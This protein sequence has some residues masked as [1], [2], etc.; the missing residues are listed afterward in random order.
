MA[1]QLAPRRRHTLQPQGV[2]PRLRGPWADAVFVYVPSVSTWQAR[3]H[4]FALDPGQTDGVSF[5][6][7][8]GYYCT[9]FP[10]CSMRA[11]G[12]TQSL[13]FNTTGM[14]VL[15]IGFYATSGSGIRNLINRNSAGNSGG[16]NVNYFNSVGAGPRI[17]SSYNHPSTG[18][19]NWDSAW[20]NGV[21]DSTGNGSFTTATNT[22]YVF[23]GTAA[24]GPAA[25]G[26]EF[27]MGK[28]SISGQPGG[29]TG[30]ELVVI[31][32]RKFTEQQMYEITRDPYQIFHAPGRLAV[33]GIASDVTVGLTGVSSTTSINGP[34]KSITKAIETPVTGTGSVGIIVP[35]ISQILAAQTAT[36]SIN[37]PVYSLATGALAALT[38]TGSVGTV[39]VEQS[40]GDRT[41]GLTGVSATGSVGSLGKS[42]D[43]GLPSLLGINI[44]GT[45]TSS[46][47]DV[48]TTGNPWRSVAFAPSV[49]PFRSVAEH[50][51]VAGN[52]SV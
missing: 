26:N 4:R 24:V 15:T 39:S 34:G 52:A 30:V 1:R 14:T 32:P 22:R 18:D 35:D 47:G 12:G 23:A 40:T 11:T 17:Y 16:F 41:I 36:G 50:A 2:F 43:I 42:V 51:S 38:G 8:F 13:A 6:E 48:S 49:A 20:V 10:D 19:T 5:A 9:Y 37:S 21:K 45:I 44:I 28:E 31:W 27:I 3:N 7:R 25:G 46:G 29:E 33:N